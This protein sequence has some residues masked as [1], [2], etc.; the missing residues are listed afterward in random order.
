MHWKRLI[1]AGIGLRVSRLARRLV[2]LALIGAAFAASFAASAPAAD[3]VRES[4]MTAHPVEWAHRVVDLTHRTI[5]GAAVLVH[6]AVRYFSPIVMNWSDMWVASDGTIWV[7]N[8]SLQSLCYT[9][10]CCSYWYWSTTYQGLQ[11]QFCTYGGR[12]Y[13]TWRRP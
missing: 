11:F 6:T 2:V 3:W 10:G 12:P 5:G 4:N 8:R 13:L 1:T 7:K 9:Y